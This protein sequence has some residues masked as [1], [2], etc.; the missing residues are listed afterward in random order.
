VSSSQG[1]MLILFDNGVPRP[2][3]GHLSSHT[4][5]ESRSLDWHAISNGELI[6]AAEKAGFDVLVTTDKN[7]RY[8][9]NLSSRR[10]ALL[11]LERPEWK[12]VRAA[13]L[14]IADA[15]QAIQPGDYVEVHVPH[16]T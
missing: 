3:R 2:L 16:I 12:L 5:I 8:Q 7:L 14:S 11:V 1:Y 9:Q 13:A 15:V 4:V 10:I 6:A